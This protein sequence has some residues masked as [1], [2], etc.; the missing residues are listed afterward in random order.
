MNWDLQIQRLNSIRP[1]EW[2]TYWDGRDHD[3]TGAEQWCSFIQ[4][5][6]GIEALAFQDALRRAIDNKRVVTVQE[7]HGDNAYVY[8]V[9]GVR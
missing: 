4:S 9:V 8:W 3:G 1:G 7:R 2:L 5:A 6:A